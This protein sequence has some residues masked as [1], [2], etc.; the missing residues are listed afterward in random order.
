MR[1]AFCAVA[2]VTLAL[3]AC[4][5]SAQDKA[6]TTVCN[7]RDDMTKQVD[8]LKSRL[9]LPDHRRDRRVPHT[10]R[11]HRPIRE[12]LATQRSSSGLEQETCITAP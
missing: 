4:G 8:A 11:Q 1:L 3:G 2:V 9:R 7:A 12:K 6:K 5:T 10:R